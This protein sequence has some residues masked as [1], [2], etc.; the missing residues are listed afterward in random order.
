MSPWTPW[1]PAVRSDPGCPACPCCRSRPW[2]RWRRSRLPGR[3]RRSSRGLR[4][5]PGGRRGPAGRLRPEHLRCPW[6]RW[7]RWSRYCRGCRSRPARRWQPCGPSCALGSCGPDRAL[8]TGRSN[9][10]GKSC[11][12]GRAGRAAARA[13]RPG[14]AGGAG[15][16]AAGGALLG[17]AGPTTL[18]VIACSPLPHLGLNET[19]PL[20][21]FFFLTQAL[22]VW[23][24]ATSAPATANTANAAAPAIA[25]TKVL[26][27]RI[28][29]PAIAFPSP[30]LR[31]A[32]V[33]SRGP[34]ALAGDWYHRRTGRVNDGRGYFCPTSSE[35]LKS[36]IPGF[37]DVRSVPPG[38]S[39]VAARGMIRRAPVLRP[40]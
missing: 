4:S 34:S 10:P 18:S 1:S 6:R 12:A 2:G 29:V 30:V 16:A 19:A 17:P 11:R 31:I 38:P 8:R 24:E 27:S 14:R 22:M 20:S 15:G 25:D 26:R 33:P 9:G 40:N 21:G 5:R 28:P 23:A 3:W 35:L 13:G 7:R 32:E 37:L 36:G 39:G